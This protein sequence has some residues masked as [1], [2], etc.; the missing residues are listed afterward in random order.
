MVSNEK[1]KIK[2]SF[3]QPGI[4]QYLDI[5]SFIGKTQMDFFLHPDVLLSLRQWDSIGP[6][7]RQSCYLLLRNDVK[8]PCR[9]SLQRLL[10]LEPIMVTES[11]KDYS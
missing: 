4:S 2:T 11:T 7:Y 9:L 1:M 10:L 5:S 8:G 6:E 3:S